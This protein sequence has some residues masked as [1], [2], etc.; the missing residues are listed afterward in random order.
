[1]FS[2]NKVINKD[3]P[4]NK[5]K[6]N[7]PIEEVKNIV[8]QH[9]D[10]YIK[11]FSDVIYEREQIRELF[12][13]DYFLNLMYNSKDLDGFVK[14]FQVKIDEKIKKLIRNTIDGRDLVVDLNSLPSYM[15]RQN[16]E[17]VSIKSVGT[18]SVFSDCLRLMNKNYKV[19]LQ[20][21]A[22]NTLTP[23]KDR[24]DYILENIFKV[25]FDMKGQVTGKSVNINKKAHDRAIQQGLSF[26]IVGITNSESFDTLDNITFYLLPLNYFHNNSQFINTGKYSDNSNNHYY[27]IKLSKIIDINK[28][29]LNLKLKEKLDYKQK[30][31]DKI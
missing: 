15:A 2:I 28:I 1:M 18:E 10:N 12:N 19:K 6:K 26:Y 17:A 7:Q 5:I 8:E 13:L 24:P 22:L 9:K 31:I 4:F 25:V 14:L 21:P 23:E 29:S 3:S 16:P 11:E 20:T 30:N 27:S